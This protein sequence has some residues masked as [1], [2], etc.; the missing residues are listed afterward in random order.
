MDWAIILGRDEDGELLSP[1]F[2]QISIN[3]LKRYLKFDAGFLDTFLDYLIEVDR[4]DEAIN[5]LY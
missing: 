4:V 1:K 3:I 2:A 5:T